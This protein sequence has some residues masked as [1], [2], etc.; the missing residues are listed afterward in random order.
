MEFSDKLL[1]LLV[2]CST[3]AFC[4]ETHE[5]L[6]DLLTRYEKATLDLNYSAKDFGWT[7][8]AFCFEMAV[9][10]PI[11]VLISELLYPK[12][13]SVVSGLLIGA[14][15]NLFAVVIETLLFKKSAKFREFVSKKNAAA[16][17]Y[18]LKEKN[19]LYDEIYDY[20]IE[21]NID[22]DSLDELRH[23]LKSTI[24]SAVLWD[25]TSPIRFE[26]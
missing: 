8:E 25:V 14:M 13:K 15:S 9:S 4:S 10:V 26:E 22:A 5:P 1:G 21:N 18:F 6:Q 17:E 7:K 23:S 20:V 12:E 11:S 24:K 19:K 3:A 16:Y 2:F